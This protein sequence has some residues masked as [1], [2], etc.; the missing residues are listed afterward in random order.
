M[1]STLWKPLT[2]TGTVVHRSDQGRRRATM[3]SL[4]R[5]FRLL[6]ER[7]R[8]AIATQVS[9]KLYNATG[10]SIPWIIVT[11]RPNT[12]NDYG[13]IL[14][15]DESRFRLDSNSKRVLIWR[16][17][18]SR[19]RATNVV[20]KDNSDQGQ[21]YKDDILAPVA[22]F[23]MEHIDQIYSLWMITR[24][25]TRVQLKDLQLKDILRLELPAISPDLNPMEHM[26]DILRRSIAA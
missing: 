19:Y 26:W 5:Y 7:D 9:R 16:E 3:P 15:S 1:V 4:N 13:R 23:S 20:E 8:S 21:L 22:D 6:S 2:E 12:E 17:Q 10:T 14:F 24:A 18:C 25:H 11:Q